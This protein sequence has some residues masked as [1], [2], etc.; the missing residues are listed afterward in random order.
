MTGIA[1]PIPVVLWG[2]MAG[3]ANVAQTGA[4]VAG[5]AIH[6]CVAAFQQHWVQKI[7][8]V[9]VFDEGSDVLNRLPLFVQFFRVPRDVDADPS[10]KAHGVNVHRAIGSDLVYE[11]VKVAGVP[12]DLAAAIAGHLLQHLWVTGRKLVCLT[13]RFQCFSHFL[14]KTQ[15]TGLI[16]FLAATS[17]EDR[18][19]GYNAQ[20]KQIVYPSH[21]NLFIN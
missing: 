6:V 19:Q 4:R 16:V 12:H 9:L 20:H 14:G 17:V 5:I 7:T 21:G 3:G 1:R 11:T 10:G 8:F 13:H 15:V 18:A 2:L